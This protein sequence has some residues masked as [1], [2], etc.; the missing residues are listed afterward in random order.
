MSAVTVPVAR[1]ASRVE[2][3]MGAVEPAFLSLVGW[4]DARRVVVFPVDH[5]VMGMPLCRVG[6]CD[7]V[8]YS[9]SGLCRYCESRWRKDGRNLDAF[10][11]AARENRRLPEQDCAVAGCPRP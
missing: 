9:A 11:E 8:A 6:D 7:C 10:T 5:P 1:S 3:L 4:S 2:E